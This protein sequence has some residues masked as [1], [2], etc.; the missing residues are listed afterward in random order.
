MLAFVERRF[1]FFPRRQ[2]RQ[3]ARN[4]V[5]GA[6]GGDA[7]QGSVS[8]DLEIKPVV[9]PFANPRDTILA[10]GRRMPRQPRQNAQ[11]D[12]NPFPDFMPLSP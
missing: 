11:P 9:T 7:G 2:R 5:Q 8:R 4:V 3:R 10:D 1:D 12:P 6:V